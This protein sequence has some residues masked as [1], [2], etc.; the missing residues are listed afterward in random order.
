MLCIHTITLVLNCQLVCNNILTPPMSLK[1]QRTRPEHPLP[2]PKKSRR[3]KLQK[4][5]KGFLVGAHPPTADRRRGSD[6]PLEMGSSLVVKMRQFRTILRFRAIF[7]RFF[8]GFAEQNPEICR[9]EIGNWARR[10]P[11]F[12]VTAASGGVRGKI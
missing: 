12:F 7:A 2:F 3:G 11:R 9:G 4:I 1:R 5:C 8:F 6:I 10:E